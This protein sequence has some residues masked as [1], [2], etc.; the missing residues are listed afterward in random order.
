[1]SSCLGIYVNENVIKFAKL[2]YEKNVLQLEKYG[3]RFVK[4]DP[5]NQIEAIIQETNSTRTPVAIT[6]EKSEF[7][8]IEMFEQGHVKAF[9]NDVTK[10]EFEAWCEKNAKSPQRYDYIY[11]SAD[12]KNV[13]G[14]RNIEINI[15]EKDVLSKYTQRFNNVSSIYPSGLLTQRLV[16]STEQNYVLVDFSDTLTV[17]VVVEGKVVDMKNYKIGMKQILQDFAG[18]LGSYQKAYE[19]CKQINVFSEG[20]DNNN[21]ELELILE[22]LLQEVLK[23]VQTYVEKYRKDI[24]KIILTGSGIIFTNIDILFTEF[25]DQ[26]C[27]I[28]KPEFLEDTSNVRNTADMLETIEA[29]SLAYDVL[30]PK[31]KESEYVKKSSVKRGLLAIFDKKPKDRK[32]AKLKEKKE[33]KLKETPKVS[34]SFFDTTRIGTILTCICIVFAVLFVSYL[35]FGT[36]YSSRVEKMKNDINNTIAKINTDISAVDSDYSYINTNMTK[37]KNINDE[38]QEVIEQ[39]ESNKIGKF[40]TYNVATFLQNIIK[41]IP[42]NVQLVNISS[43]DNKNVKITAQSSSYADLGYFVAELKINNTLNSI[44]VNNVKNS[45]TTIIE[46]GGEL[47]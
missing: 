39:I 36:I 11:K 38:V 25:M 5:L 10:M 42:K 46:I 4:I 40:S 44:K 27:E 26:R 8:N 28:L 14:K 37:Y 20:M 35:A 16:P 15:V 29:M 3:T 22:P 34:I 19:A 6:P 1:M 18:K 9:F 31:P 30:L 21:R 45:E 32:E 23:N 13:D 41:I 17:I 2:S 7:I 12:A 33:T 24:E 43:D 47:P